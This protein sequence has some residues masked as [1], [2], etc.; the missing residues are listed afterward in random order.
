MTEDD[1]FNLDDFRVTPEFLAGRG[2]LHK[3]KPKH[4]AAEAFIKRPLWWAQQLTKASHLATSPV[5]DCLL[6][7]EFKTRRNPVSLSGEALSE[8]GI[9]RQRS[10]EA[11]AEL[12]A[13]GLVSVRHHHGKPPVV[14]LIKPK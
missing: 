8:W 1:D 4:Q 9:T 10:S 2:K 12:E 13:L 5:A 7:Q 11:L 14:T 3:L 6:R